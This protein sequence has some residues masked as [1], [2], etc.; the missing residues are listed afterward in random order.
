MKVTWPEG[1]DF[2][3]V[4]VVHIERLVYHNSEGPTL[5]L[6]SPWGKHMMPEQN[7]DNNVSLRMSIRMCYKVGKK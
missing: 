4:N 2:P 7:P 3:Y 6:K 5:G 1:F